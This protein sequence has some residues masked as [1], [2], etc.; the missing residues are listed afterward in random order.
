MNIT[1]HHKRQT[2][3]ICGGDHLDMFL[4]L[5]NQ[6]LAN[7]FLKT[8]DEFISEARYPL[9]VYFCKK[10]GLV[11]LL[12]VIDPEV[13]FRQ[14][15]YISGTSATIAEHNLKYAYFVTNFLNLNSSDLV[16][17]IASNDGSLLRCFRDYNI[18]VLGVE[19]ATN[20]AEIAKGFGIETINRFFNSK[21]AADI[22]TDY[23]LARAVIGNNVL[24]HID[25][26]RDFLLGCKK[27]LA[28]DGLIVIE[29]PYLR[30]LLE[31]VE[32]DTIYH[33]HL[34]YFSVS[35][36]MKLFESVGLSVVKV[37]RI[38]VH[39]GSI[40][41]YAGFPGVVTNHTKE[42]M[43]IVN[44]EQQLG[45]S[46]LNCYENFA[47][48]VQK[49]RLIL[50]NLLESLR[51]DGKTIAG[52]GAPAKGNT[53]LNYCSINEELIK[54]T[55]DKNPLKVG[56]YTPGTHIPILPVETILE[57]MP[58]Y[59]LILAWNFADEIMHQEQEY[60]QRGGRFII[61]IPEAVV[62]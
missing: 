22:L 21:T 45:L 38:P 4:S 11:Q 17:E 34:C 53:L 16:I 13:L 28:R 62:V 43:D 1:P 3:R 8:K 58:D 31:Q 5:G 19:P 59:V 7:S 49:S 10:C 23:G 30:D 9:N 46:D 60:H 48:D 54:F 40:R 32:Y 15:I 36:L 57:Q 29:V 33:E 42:V 61:P 50:I 47:K 2:C 26:P 55:V 37:D 56:L 18:R 35:S 20:I 12:D 27:L 24:A 51:K 52:Y 44:E 25:D 14:Y 6:P 41:I 39:G